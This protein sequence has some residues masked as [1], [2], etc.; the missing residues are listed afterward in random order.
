[1][2]TDRSDPYNRSGPAPVRFGRTGQISP[3]RLQLCHKSV[4]ED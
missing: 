3:G 2:K 1:M 4:P